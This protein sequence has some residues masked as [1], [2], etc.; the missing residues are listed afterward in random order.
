MLASGFDIGPISWPHVNVQ[1]L[2]HGGLS[3]DSFV[4]E[5]EA[6]SPNQTLL[7]LGKSLIRSNATLP[8]AAILIYT[9]V[10]TEICE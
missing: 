8:Q 1:T 5:P 6:E 9:S 10:V 4:H 7:C 2:S 3:P